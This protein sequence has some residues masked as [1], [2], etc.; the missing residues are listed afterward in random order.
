MM[1]ERSMSVLRIARSRSSR[2][3]GEDV[4]ERLIRMCMKASA[5][6]LSCEIDRVEVLEKQVGEKKEKIIQ[7]F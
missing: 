5:I 1:D 7:S 6:E 2:L 4:A 3:S